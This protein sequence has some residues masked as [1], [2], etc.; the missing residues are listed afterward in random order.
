MLTETINDDNVIYDKWLPKELFERITFKK[1]ASF[2]GED[3][4]AFAGDI[5]LDK[6]KVGYYLDSG[7]GGESTIN[8]D[9]PESE[10]V[11]KDIFERNNVKTH[12]HQKC[13]WSFYPTPDDINFDD[14]FNAFTEQWEAKERVKKDEKKKIHFISGKYAHVQAT[15]QLPK[16]WHL[17]NEQAKKVW[18]KNLIDDLKNSEQQYKIA[19]ENIL[20]YI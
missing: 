16:N 5:Y 17:V 2:M 19:S 7:N 15:M 12:M 11:I 6:K 9:K 8:F 18:V 13:G 1:T 20:Q 14:I 10:K 4:P 3:M